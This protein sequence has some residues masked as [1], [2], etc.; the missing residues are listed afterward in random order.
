MALT[1]PW[2]TRAMMV[3]SVAPPTRRSR[4]ARTVTRALTSRRMPSLATA[5]SMVRAL[6]RIGAVDDLR[7]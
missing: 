6:G 7:D 3:S 5:S 1:M 2:P 4:L